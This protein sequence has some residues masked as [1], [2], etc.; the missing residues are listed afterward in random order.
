LNDVNELWAGDMSGTFNGDIHTAPYTIV[1]QSKMNGSFQGFS[2][3]KMAGKYYADIEIYPNSIRQQD[4][5]YIRGNYTMIVKDKGVII[6]EG[7]AKISGALQ[8]ELKIRIRGKITNSENING[9]WHGVAKI[10]TIAFKDNSLK[11]DMKLPVSGLIE[12]GSPQTS[13]TLSH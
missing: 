1:L 10:E 2:K 13:K 9:I 5:G 12:N 4:I 3:G 6:G 8:G 11:I 7:N